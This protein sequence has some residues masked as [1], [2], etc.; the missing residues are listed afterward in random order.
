MHGNVWEWCED[1]YDE[2]EKYKVL[3]GG[4]WSL[5]A[6]NARSANRNRD[7]PTNRSSNVGFRLLRTLP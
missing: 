2:E 7:N 1:W 3:R 5:D 4:S 6:G